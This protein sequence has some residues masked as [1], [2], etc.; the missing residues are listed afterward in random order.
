[1]FA[2][3]AEAND[4]LKYLRTLESWFGKLGN[5]SE[6]KELDQL[7][8]PILHVVLLIWKNSRYYNSPARLVVLVRMICNAVINAALKHVNGGA[9]FEAIESASEGQAIAQLQ[10]VLGVCEALKRTYD[11]YKATANAECPDNPWRIQSNALFLRLDAFVERCHDVLEMTEAI[12]KFRKLEKV[13]IGGSKGAALEAAVLAIRADFDAAVNAFK[14]VKYDI[15]QV[16]EASFDDDYYALRTA[17]RELERRLAA[18]LT[19]GFES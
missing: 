17:F 11:D 4:N 10:D 12:Q 7:F 19:Q 16:E 5:P 18:I 8:R 2:A 1:V 13:E 6:F 3:R 15:L 14:E 9:V